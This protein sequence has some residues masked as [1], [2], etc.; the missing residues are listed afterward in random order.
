[1]EITHIRKCEYHYKC[2]LYS[3]G[4]EACFENHELCE[5]YNKRKETERNVEKERRRYW[6]LNDVGILRMLK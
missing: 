4:S 5:L 2:L 3:A 6:E 1:M